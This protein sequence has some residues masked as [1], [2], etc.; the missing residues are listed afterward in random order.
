MS[1]LTCV[2]VR[3][4]VRLEIDRAIVGEPAGRVRREERAPQRDHH[5]H[6]GHTLNGII[7]RDIESESN[8][9]GYGKS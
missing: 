4:G 7:I 5:S 8:V 2:A 1:L 6:G 3:A 9:R